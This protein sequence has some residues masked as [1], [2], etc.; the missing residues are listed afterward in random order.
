[1]E[2]FVERYP[3]IMPADAVGEL[4]A[5]AA[6]LFERAGIPK[7]ALAVWLPRFADAARGFIAVER[8]RRVAITTSHVEKMGRLSFAAPGGAFTLTGRADRIDVL[9]DG[10]A[11]I[12][13][14][15]SGT[16]PSKKQVEQLLAPQLPLEAAMLA[17]DGFGIG[18][19]L[20]EEL[21]YLS[22][23]DG[24]HAV[25]P[26]CIPNGAALGAQALARLKQRVARFD[27]PATS[28]QSRIMPFR[29]DSVGDYDHLARVREWSAI[30]EEA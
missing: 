19:F 21:I 10:S 22:L 28:Y 12:V 8:G 14:Y 16:M 2:A 29:I 1:V 7:A 30:A 24:R 9:R 26:T 25:D 27:D 5:I 15:K 3:D 23:A 20:A 13:D 6:K 4:T 11:A 18:R 17:E